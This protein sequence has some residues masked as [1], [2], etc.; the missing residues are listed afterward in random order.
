L[1]RLYK[2]P[3]HSSFAREAR[4]EPPL[5]HSGRGPGAIWAD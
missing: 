5:L 1:A 4:R 3:S 2:T